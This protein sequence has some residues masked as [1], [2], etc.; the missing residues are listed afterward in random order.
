MRRGVSPR[1]GCRCL[2]TASL[3][4]ALLHQGAISMS[5]P[6]RRSMRY[7]SP[8]PQAAAH[9]SATHIADYLAARADWIIALSAYRSS[10]LVRSI[11]PGIAGYESGEP[12]GSYSAVY[13]Q[14]RSAEILAT[15]S[16]A[17]YFP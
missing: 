2:S 8:R 7:H 4:Q 12:V 11:G 15:D 6:V 3:L 17:A 16:V 14:V 5:R 9:G 10:T 13:L 1:P